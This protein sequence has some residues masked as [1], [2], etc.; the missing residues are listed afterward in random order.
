MDDER[1]RQ[2]LRGRLLAGAAS[3]LTNPVGKK[4]FAALRLR[5]VEASNSAS[6]QAVQGGTQKRHE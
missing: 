3:P 5:C 4:Y 1:G 2:L 6:D